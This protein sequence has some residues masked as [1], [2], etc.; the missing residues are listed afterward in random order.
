MVI[1]RCCPGQAVDGS[2]VELS[3]DHLAKCI[4]TVAS[5]LTHVRAVRL[6]GW[7]P[8]ALSKKCDMA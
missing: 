6:L 3:V 7:G 1:V 8:R 5:S 2:W 4:K